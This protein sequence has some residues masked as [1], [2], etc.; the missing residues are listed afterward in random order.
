MT[1]TEENID[2]QPDCKQLV[3]TFNFKDFVSAWAFMSKVALLA[4]KMDHH[5]NWS[6]QYNKVTIRLTTHS[7]GNKITEKDQK[8]AQQIDKV[9]V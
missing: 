5:P 7:E 9:N 8:L 2:E 1:W 3:K 6:N 4:E